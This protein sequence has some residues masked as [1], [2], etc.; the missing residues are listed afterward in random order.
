MK[1]VSA[2]KNNAYVGNASFK[3]NILEKEQFIWHFS[4]LWSPLL[5]TEEA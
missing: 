1:T 4:T 5:L 2:R 3:T